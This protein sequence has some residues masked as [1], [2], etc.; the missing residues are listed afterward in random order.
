MNYVVI[1]MRNGQYALGA[2]SDE[3]DVDYTLHLGGMSKAQARKQA[4]VLN[5]ARHKPEPECPIKFGKSHPG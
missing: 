2:T 3:P 1:S 4:D 5:A